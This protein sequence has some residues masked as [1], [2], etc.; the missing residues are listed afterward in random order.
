[1]RIE[2]NVRAVVARVN[3][4]KDRDI[5]AALRAALKPE[6]WHEA[7][8]QEA[9]RTLLALADPNQRAFIQDFLKTLMSGV[10]GNPGFY[11]RMR[12]PFNGS[13]TLV[14]YQAAHGVVKPSDLG[15]NL[16]Q[17]DLQDF[18]ALMTE[19]VEKEK[20]KDQRDA[21]KTDEEIGGF[22]TRIMLTRDPTI[23]QARARA[24]L[25]PHIVDFLQRQQAMSKLDAAVV[26]A[27]LRAVLCAWRE[28]AHSR[29]PELFHA[30]LQTSM[31]ELPME[32][33]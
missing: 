3:R 7:A 15:Q 2:S 30:A 6:Q 11:L 14:D 22:I 5:P 4:L 24:G 32:G 21:G 33:R 16:F 18:Q 23:R 19:W 10:F 29:F 31:S 26:D 12:S 20:N 25:L 17:K 28:L 27:W 9:E 13:Q 8:R 1:M